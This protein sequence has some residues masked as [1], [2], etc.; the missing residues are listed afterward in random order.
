MLETKQRD[1]NK[2]KNDGKISFVGMVKCDR[3]VCDLDRLTEMDDSVMKIG[4]TPV[5]LSSCSVITIM[6]HRTRDLKGS[7]V[8]LLAV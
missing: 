8:I 4:T 2:P 3:F 1:E 5:A 7:K 6:I